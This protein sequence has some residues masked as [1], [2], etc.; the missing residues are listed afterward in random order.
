MT[1]V[2]RFSRAFSEWLRRYEQEP[3]RFAKEWPT[4]GEYGPEA[5]AFFVKL[6]AETA[7]A[8]HGHG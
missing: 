5:A 7:E 6:L 1:E 4:S 3:E 2:E 8:G